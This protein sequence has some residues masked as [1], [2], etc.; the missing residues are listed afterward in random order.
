MFDLLDLGPK[1]KAVNLRQLPPWPA[2]GWKP[3]QPH[4]WPDIRGADLIAV[5]LETKETQFDKGPGWARDRGHIIGV[6]LAAMSSRTNERVGFYLPI[7][8]EVEGEL[9]LP[10]ENVLNYTRAMLETSVPKTGANML[11]DIGW[12]GEENINPGGPLYDVQFAEA[13]LDEQ[14]ATALDWLGE[15][16]LG[17][18]KTTSQLYAWLSRAY[19]GAAGGKQRANLYRSPPSLAG[20][21]AT[22]DALMPLDI[23]PLQWAEMSLQNLLPLY[24]MECRLIRVLIK[25]RREGVSIDLPYVERLYSDLGG[26]IEKLHQQFAYRWGRRCNMSSG[27]DI[28]AVFDAHGIPYM[29]TAPTAGAPNGNP[30]F[31]KDWLAHNEHPICKEIVAIRELEKL[32][33]TFV[34]SYLLESN[35]NGKVFCQFHP[36]RTSKQGG[37]DDTNG[38]K[39]GRFAS[40]DPNLQNIP[41]RTEAGKK[42][43]RAFIPDRG[44]ACWRKYDYSQIEYRFLAHYAV[45]A[46]DGSAD[47]L[48]AS[49][50]N[51]PNVDYHDYVYDQACPYMGWDATDKALRK[52]KRRPIKN[53]NFGLLYGQGQGRLARTMGF[54]PEQARTFFTAYHDAAPYVKPTMQAC[55]DEIHQ[56]GFITTILGRRTRFNEWVPFNWRDEEDAKPL[57]FEEAIRIYGS[58]IERANVYRGVNYKFQG[59]AADQMKRGIDLC[60]QSGVFDYTGYPRLTVHD[61]LDFSLR[62]KSP[63]TLE[64]FRFMQHT[65]ENAI[66][67]RIP[68]RMDPEEGSNWADTKELA[69]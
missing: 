41:V 44:H 20:P 10:V 65:M 13:L 2:T 67:L 40:S 39:T 17:H 34:R 57:P 37:G 32:R 48:R 30:S 51:D 33:S 22:E 43:R 3:L 27:G 11:Y 23:L 25:M 29:R 45:D 68:V 63:A 4:E 35:V 14:G 28:A 54:T 12:L 8:H 64:A 69:A 46:G 62:D 60:E 58:N 56:F 21:Y 15:K 24:E 66:A 6:A 5:D 1:R 42:I 26:D 50:A 18:G 59:S 53:T 16:Y 47:K 61:E 9:N 7:R 31:K 38:A 36:L 19:G 52:D 55:A 49:Y